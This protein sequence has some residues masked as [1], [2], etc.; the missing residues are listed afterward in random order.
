MC[1]ITMANAEIDWEREG[2]RHWT[3]VISESFTWRILNQKRSGRLKLATYRQ[4]EILT[5][6]I[7]FH[8]NARHAINPHKESPCQKSMRSERKIFRGIRVPQQS[9]QIKIFLS[10][11]PFFLLVGWA[12]EQWSEENIWLDSWSCI[13]CTNNSPARRPMMYSFIQIAKYKRFFNF[14]PMHIAFIHIHFTL[15]FT[16]T[17][18]FSV[19]CIGRVVEDIKKENA[20]VIKV[21]DGNISHFID[22]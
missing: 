10:D 2:R 20:G 21:Q 15:P 7:Y 3:G 14:T 1:W 8:K 11:E 22:L 19:S 12:S 18:L 5:I 9:D 4:F 13:Q 16:H 6:P 17:N